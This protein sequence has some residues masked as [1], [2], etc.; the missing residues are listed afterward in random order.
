MLLS[1]EGLKNVS[2]EALLIDFQSHQFQIDSN[3]QAAYSRESR[4]TN[5]RLIIICE[6]LIPNE[7]NSHRLQTDSNMRVADSELIY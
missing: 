4:V 2:M 5:S 6:H 3:I 7:I 1:A